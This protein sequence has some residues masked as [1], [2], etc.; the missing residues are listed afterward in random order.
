MNMTMKLKPSHF[1]Q[2]RVLG[3][4]KKN[5]LERTQVIQW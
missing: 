2:Y 3:G 4:F 5:P 1:E